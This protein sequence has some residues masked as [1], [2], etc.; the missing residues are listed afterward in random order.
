MDYYFDLILGALVQGNSG[1]DLSDKLAPA[2]M[3]ESYHMCK[4]SDLSV[5]DKLAPAGMTESC[6]MCKKKLEGS[7]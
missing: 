2:G 1:E 4:K 3:T 7:V 6:H 5:S